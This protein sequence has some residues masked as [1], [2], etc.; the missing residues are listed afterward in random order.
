MDGHENEDVGFQHGS[1]G[2][3]HC[4]SSGMSTNPLPEKVSGMAMSSGSM[5]KPSN[6][7]DHFFSSGWDPLVSLSHS[8]NFGGS[9]MVSHSE[10]SNP[11]Y[12]VVMENQGIST[13]FHLV[14]Y[15][16]SST[17]VE[18]VPKLPC[19]GS[20]SFSEMVNSFGLPDCSQIANSGCPQNYASNKDGG[21]GKT[22]TN[23]AQSQDDHQ[24]SG[25]GAVGSSPNAKRRKRAPDSNN[26]PF[27]PHQNAEGELQKDLS[28]E[29]SEVLK[30]PDEKK[31]KIEQNTGSNLRGKQTS[32]QA[33]D[34]SS[35]DGSKDNYIHV[36]ARRGQATNSHSLAERVR[37]EKIS[38]RMRLLQ[39]LVPGCNKITG[40][41]VM[42]D[43]II[44]YVQSLQQQVEFLSMKLATVNP[45]LNI[46][47]EQILSKDIIHSRASTGAILGFGPGMSSTHRYPHGIFQGSLPS[48]PTATPKFPSLPQTMLDNELHNLFQM[49]FDSCPVDNLGPNAGHLKPEL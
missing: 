8:E 46:D 38:E 26:P 16:S 24:I 33:K 3:L 4:P 22:S 30:E 39:E 1:D 40:K 12:P 2:V 42:L 32:K 49:G 41:A 13:S 27:S 14:Q 43:E 35:G 34:T 18:P 28:G 21:T 44:N 37:R 19:F 11:P 31:P 6:G 36:R 25:E 45:E 20:G 23:A 48:I 9:S 29:S 15:P 10:F 5:Y 7:A 17:L 47:M